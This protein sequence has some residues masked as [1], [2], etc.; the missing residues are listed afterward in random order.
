M[1]Y[2]FTKAVIYVVETRSTSSKPENTISQWRT[3]QGDSLPG[4]VSTLNH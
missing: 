1:L 4:Q 2:V 3:G